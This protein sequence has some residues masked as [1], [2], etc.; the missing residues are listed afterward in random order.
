MDSLQLIF[1]LLALALLAGVLIIANFAEVNKSL[2]LLVQVILLLLN[3]I[4]VTFLGILPLLSAM[5]PTSFSTTTK[6]IP[7]PNAIAA[8]ILALVIGSLASLV[9]LP[10]V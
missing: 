10:T 8:F 6:R 4:F 2:H 3:G 1:T 5:T 9:L 7:L